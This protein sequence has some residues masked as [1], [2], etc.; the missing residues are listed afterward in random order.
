MAKQKLTQTGKQEQRNREF[1]K[2]AP[3]EC[4]WLEHGGTNLCRLQGVLHE[5]SMYSI[6][7]TVTIIISTL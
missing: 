1:T 4:Y 5:V 3:N 7:S 2:Q 6:Q